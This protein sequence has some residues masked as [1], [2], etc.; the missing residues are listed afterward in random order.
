MPI[1][2]R[3]EAQVWAEQLAHNYK[4]VARI[5]SIWGA[6]T[7]DRTILESEDIIKAIQSELPE[8]YQQDTVSASRVLLQIVVKRYTSQKL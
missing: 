2:T 7:N 3:E 8:G 1:M 4:L 6:G 5:D